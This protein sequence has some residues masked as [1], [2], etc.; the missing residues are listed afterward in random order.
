MNRRLPGM[1]I[2]K[3]IQGFLQF[4]AAEGLSIKTIIPLREISAHGS[5]T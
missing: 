2:V 1:D 4:K 3:A 5:N